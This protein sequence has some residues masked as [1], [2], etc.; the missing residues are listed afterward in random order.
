MVIGQLHHEKII[1]CCTE[2][3][4]LIVPHNCFIKHHAKFE[5][6]KK[7]ITYLNQ[8]TDITNCRT[9]LNIKRHA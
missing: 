7:I 6:I 2:D 4:F 1:K 8:P 5:N 9:T 3:I